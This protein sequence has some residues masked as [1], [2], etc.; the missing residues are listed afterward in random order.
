MSEKVCLRGKGKTLLGVANKLLKTK[1]LLSSPSN[2]LPLH[3]N[4]T[5]LP[6]IW[7][8]IEGE[9]D[10]IQSRLPFKLPLCYYI[11][12]CTH[13]NRYRTYIP[14][15]TESFDVLLNQLVL[16]NVLKDLEYIGFAYPF[17]PKLLIIIIARSNYSCIKLCKRL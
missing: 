17:D 9:G 10:G 4:Q 16:H 14:V 15:C 5:L 13:K 1:S 7:I 8:F 2:V 6:M 11:I 3:L 12:V